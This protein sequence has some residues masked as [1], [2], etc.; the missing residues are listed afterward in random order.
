MSYDSKPDYNMTPPTFEEVVSYAQK[1]GLYG[2]ISLSKFYD[3]YSKR[4][5]SYNGYLMDWRSKMKEWAARQTAPVVETAKECHAKP[6]QEIRVDLLDDI[7]R[8]FSLA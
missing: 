4:G 5:F 1:A 2:K 6:K 3:Y 8:V 7:R